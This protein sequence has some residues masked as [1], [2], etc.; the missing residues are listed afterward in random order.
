[1]S[2]GKGAI[3]IALAVGAAIGAGI[4]WVSKSFFDKEEKEKMK[5]DNEKAN[6]DLKT[7]LDTFKM[8]S[9]RM[10]KIVAAVMKEKPKNEHEMS[11]LLKRHGLNTV[12]IEKILS[13]LYPDEACR[14]AV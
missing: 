8:E 6:H 14:G 9:A 3:A 13:S 7:V 5:K 11:S 1:M 4:S 12:Q 10:E 2:S